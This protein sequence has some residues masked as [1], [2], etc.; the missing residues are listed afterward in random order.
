MKNKGMVVLFAVFFLSMSL[1]NIFGVKE[2]FSESERRVLA[3]FPEISFENIVSGDFSDEFEDYVVDHF[4]KRDSWRR[5]KAYAKTK[6]LAQKDN[7]GFFQAEGHL[8]KLEYPMDTRMLDHAIKVFSSVKEQYLQE[9]EDGGNHIYLSVIPDKNRYLASQNGYLSMNYDEFSKYM[10]DAMPYASYIE[11]ADLLETDDYYVTDTHWR[12]EKIVDVVKRIG[13]F[14]GVKVEQEYSKECLDLPFYGVYV[15]QSAM[16]CAPDTIYYLQND[17][18]EQFVVEGA[19]AVYDLK[20]ADGR[21][22]YEMFLSG[23]QPVVTIKNKLSPTGKKLI[24]FRDSFGSAI[25]P[26][27][28]TGYAEIVLVD[29]RYVSSSMIGQF[30]DFENADVLFL[31]STMLLNQSQVLK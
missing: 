13:K 1:W 10:K 11:I 15:G 7:N 4:Q 19:D 20:M 23:N 24:I 6:V 14:M 17:T 28:A 2:T 26:L 27:L 21:D 18:I 25:A 22:P 12:Q 31:Y 30:V 3:K 5:I 9:R 29:L 16:K 8:S